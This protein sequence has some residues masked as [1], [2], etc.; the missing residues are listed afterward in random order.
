MKQ[1]FENSKRTELFNRYI[2][3]ELPFIYRVC[4]RFSSSMEEAKEYFS[5]A[6]GNI[7]QYINTYSPQLHV[8]P[9]LY[10]IIKH[11]IAARK[12]EDTNIHL[13]ERYH[14]DMLVHSDFVS[15]R[16]LEIERYEDYYSE[17]IV[18]GL[19][20]MEPARR[21]AVLMQQGGYKVWEIT[22]KLY[23]DGHIPA[24]N[25]E[26]TKRYLREGKM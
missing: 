13:I 15:E 8:R 24:N 4:K 3:S 12:K 16:C 22:A 21:K 20:S 17:V 23:S 2:R 7:F 26:I 18:D 14:A 19:K 5:E 9:W 25:I 10:V 1:E 11:L 6:T